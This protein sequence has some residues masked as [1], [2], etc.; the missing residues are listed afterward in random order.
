LSS[1]G[2]AALTPAPTYDASERD[3]VYRALVFIARAL[4]RGAPGSG[5]ARARPAMRVIV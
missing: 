1:T 4:T 5:H 2:S 3:A